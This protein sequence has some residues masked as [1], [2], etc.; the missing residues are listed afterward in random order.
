MPTPQATLLFVRM[1]AAT[2]SRPGKP[3]TAPACSNSL[4]WDAALLICAAA[5]SDRSSGPMDVWSNILNSM[6]ILP[7]RNKAQ[8]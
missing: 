8:G 3:G 7:G 2:M 6:I 4:R 1:Y 5:I